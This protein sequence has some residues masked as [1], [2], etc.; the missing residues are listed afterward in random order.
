MRS[1]SLIS[2]FTFRGDMPEVCGFN[3]R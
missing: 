2:V 1:C 3:S